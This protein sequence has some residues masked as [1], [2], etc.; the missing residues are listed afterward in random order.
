M[1]PPSGASNGGRER[2]PS[3]NPKSTEKDQCQRHL[4]H[5]G[6]HWGFAHSGGLTIYPSK[7]TD[8]ETKLRGDW[9]NLIDTH[10]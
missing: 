8:E 1:N 6:D 9:R 10:G 5:S 4:G 7:W 2:C 3:L